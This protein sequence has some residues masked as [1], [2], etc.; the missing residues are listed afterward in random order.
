VS[1]N[2]GVL[3]RRHASPHTGSGDII[4]GASAYYGVRAYNGAY[5]AA[6]GPAFDLRR[7]S[8]NGTMTATV[9]GSGGLDIATISAWAGADTITI[10]RAYDQ[11]GNNRHVV[12]ATAANQEQLLLTGG[13]GNRPYI[14][15][16]AAPKQLATAATFTPATGVVS[17][18][19]VAMR[20]G[21]VATQFLAQTTGRNSIQG[22]DQGTAN[23]WT[24]KAIAGTTTRLSAVAADSVWHIGQGVMN[25]AS[26]VLSIDGIDTAG[27]VNGTT[28]AANTVLAFSAAGGV[29][30][31]RYDDNVAWSSGDRA[32]L[33]ANQ[34]AYYS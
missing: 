1:F 18:S 28:T 15:A 11:S 13:M 25:G 22:N 4:S 7:S 23:R 31:A 17:F 3:A 30:E 5:A 24:L 33:Y 12:Q 32:L 8:D 2:S 21:V 29:C 9:L 19:V 27:T 6:N 16:A 14:V 34:S 20:A 26:S 10:S